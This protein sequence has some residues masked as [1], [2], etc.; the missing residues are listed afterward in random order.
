MLEDAFLRS[1]RRHD[2]TFELQNPSGGS[3]LQWV[4]GYL[5]KPL[6]TI[7]IQ[8]HKYKYTNTKSKTDEDE[9]TLHVAACCAAIF[10]AAQDQ[11]S[12]VSHVWQIVSETFSFI[13]NTRKVHA[14]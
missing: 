2:H 3:V 4:G 6:G 13:S 14:E 11:L 12:C 7:Q 9:I 10:W 1:R 8:T 5:L